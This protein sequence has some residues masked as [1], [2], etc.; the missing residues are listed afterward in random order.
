VKKRGKV[1][2]FCAL[3]YHD[4][5]MQALAIEATDGEPGLAS[6]NKR[7]AERKEQLI[8]HVVLFINRMKYDCRSNLLC[9][10]K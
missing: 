1:L 7:R 9:D 2:V 4:G 5:R 6:G 8:V 3:C 10:S